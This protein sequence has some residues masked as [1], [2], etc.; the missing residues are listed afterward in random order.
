MEE[1]TFKIV[2]KENNYGKVNV[3]NMGI[4][5]SASAQVEMLE[6]MIIKPFEEQLKKDT[7]YSEQKIP[8]EKKSEQR[9]IG[10][11]MFYIDIKPTQTQK[12]AEVYNA[13]ERYIQGLEQCVAHGRRREGLRTA[14]GEESYM[15]LED[16]V[17]H[18]HQSIADNTKPNVEIKIKTSKGKEDKEVTKAVL[19][20]D[21]TRDYSKTEGKGAA[22]NARDYIEAKKIA[23]SIDA[24][25]TKPFE[26]A[27]KDATGFSKDSIPSVVVYTK[28][29]VGN[30]LCYGVSSPADN[31]SYGKIVNT[32]IGYVDSM[33]EE[34]GKEKSSVPELKHFDGKAF[35]SVAAL[36]K[37][38]EESKKDNTATTIRQTINYLRRPKDDKIIIE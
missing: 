13:M 8:K 15:L 19:Q 30:V 34:A 5:L 38:L 28:N 25:I 31:V 26:K 18:L 2:G 1:T 9:R 12:Y 10:N 16:V 29:P 17:D 14:N 3:P 7:G 22:D 27:V 6:A 36:N 32:I 37:K 24:I 33:S 4:Y 21:Y 35:V 23:S 20:L 11:H